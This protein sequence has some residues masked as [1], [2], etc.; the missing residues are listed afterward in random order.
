M[1]RSHGPSIKDPERYEAMRHEGMSKE[2]AARI[3]NTPRETAGKRGGH[4]ENYEERS[5]DE[6]LKKAKDVGL[7]VSTRMKKAEIIS[8]LRHH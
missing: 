4:A 7:H 2:K 6:L 3:S 1:A 5:K 8:Q